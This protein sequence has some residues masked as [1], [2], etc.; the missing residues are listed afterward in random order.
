MAAPVKLNFKI[1]QGSTFREVLRWES[2]TK[3]Y[4]PITAVTKTAPVVVTAV[5]HGAPVGWRAKVT[6]VVGMKEINDAENY[7]TITAAAA[8]TVTI[9]SINATNYTTYTSGGILEYNTPVDLT[10]YTARMQ[11][12]PTLTSTTI[13]QELTTANGGVVIDNALKTITLLISASQT[14]VLNFSTAVY[15]LELVAGT[16]VV[17]FCGGNVTLVPEVTR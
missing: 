16:E 11:I 1:Y 9:N 3:T 6:G 13:I 8:N 15:S 17:P 14:T 10:G 2:S 4:V 5:D 7:R 12:R